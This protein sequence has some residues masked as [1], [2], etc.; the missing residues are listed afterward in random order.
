MDPTS[1]SVIVVV[2]KEQHA[3]APSS[4]VPP[5]KESRKLN[6]VG[7]KVC[8]TAATS[9]KAAS[10]AALL[11]RYDRSL[12]ESLHQFV[13]LLPKDEREDFQEILNEGLM[14]S[15]QVI[16]AA[17]DNSLLSAHEYCHGV[18]LQRHSWLR[19]TSFKPEAQLRIA[20]LPFSGTTH[21]GSHA[22]EEMSRMKAEM[23]TLKAVGLEK[24]KEQ[25]KTFRPFKRRYSSQGFPCFQGRQSSQQQQQFQRSFQPFQKRQSRGRNNQ[26]SAQGNKARAGSKL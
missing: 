23:E 13:D 7:R 15:N 6:S 25:R 8:D 2:A 10:S 3:T 11:G 5:D 14:V 26:Q 22:D 24:P 1:D 19:L 21:F 4:T 18:A 9:M 12:W 16:S 17:A 20:N